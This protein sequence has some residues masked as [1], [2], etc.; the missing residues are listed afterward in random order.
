MTQ[1]NTTLPRQF[2]IL[3]C[4]RMGR[5]HAERLA[6]DGRG[7]VVALFD[8]A[9]SAAEQ[10]QNEVAPKARVF[11][12]FEE[13]MAAKRADAVIICTP[14]LEHFA[15]ATACLEQGLDVLCEKP[16][17]ATRAE[18]V[19]LIEECRRRSARLTVAYQRRFWSAYRTLRREI[20]SGAWGQVHAV[21]SHNA[22]N[23]QQVY[24]GTWR[25]DPHANWGGFI[26]D[27][28]SHKID[29]LFYVTGRAPMEVFARCDNR[30][31]RVEVA[32]GVSATCDNGALLTMDFI[33]NAQHFGEHLHIHCDKADFIVQGYTLWIVRDQGMERFE[34]LAPETDPVAGFL[35]YLCDGGENPAPPDCALPVFDFT[36]AIL[37]SNRTGRAVSVDEAKLL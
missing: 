26:G 9:R 35:D 4:G 3:G 7:E 30:G 25:D 14:T 8:T 37:A 22:E 28:G 32:A 18:I 17:A 21:M 13:L 12:T 34:P 29:V 10:L 16:L 5:T 6:K 19:S 27:A 1:H 36:Q 11:D 20:L 31:S 23:W 15:Q 33:G 24:G 2:A